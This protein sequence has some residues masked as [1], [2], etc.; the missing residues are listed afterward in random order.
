MKIRECFVSNSSSSSFIIDAGNLQTAEKMITK[1]Y[2]KA[3]YKKLLKEHPHWT[4]R[5]IEDIEKESF[6]WFKNTYELPQS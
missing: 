5:N 3:V 6:E 4:F 1:A 2:A